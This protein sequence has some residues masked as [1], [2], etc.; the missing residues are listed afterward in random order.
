MKSEKHQ[1]VVAFWTT[2]VLSPSWLRAI[3]LIVYSTVGTKP[4]MVISVRSKKAEI[5]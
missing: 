2:G 3:T 1:P 5:E 4:R